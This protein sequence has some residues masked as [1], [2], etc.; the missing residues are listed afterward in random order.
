MS[1]QIAFLLS[2]YV[3]VNENKSKHAT[4]LQS[5]QDETTDSKKSLR[6]T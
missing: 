4:V 1:P 3:V 2:G 5:Q 6:K